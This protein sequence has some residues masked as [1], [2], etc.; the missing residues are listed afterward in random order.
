MEQINKRWFINDNKAIRW[1]H[2]FVRK[3]I[4]YD[5]MVTHLVVSMGNDLNAAWINNRGE[6]CV[7]EEIDI[8]NFFLTK[9]DCQME[10]I[11]RERFE[12]K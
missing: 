2:T 6:G 1:T 11:R 10:I 3:H 4:E 12:T 8:K 9:E 5:N 7:L